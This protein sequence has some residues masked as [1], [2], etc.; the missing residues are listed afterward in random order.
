[1]IEACCALSWI[2]VAPVGPPNPSLKATQYYA[3]IPCL[4]SFFLAVGENL[5]GALV[6]LPPDLNQLRENIGNLS[7]PRC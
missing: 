5:A 3:W 6:E 7:K 1:M 2:W 4:F